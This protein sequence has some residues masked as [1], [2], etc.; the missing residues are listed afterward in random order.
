[1]T[2]ELPEVDVDR[3]N[4]AR[5]YD[6]MLGGSHN[7]ASDRA[8]GDAM[9][10]RFPDAAKAGH[11]NREFLHRAV[12]HCC[13]LGITQFLDLG[14]GIPTRGGVHEFVERR[15][16]GARVVYVDIEPVAVACCRALVEGNPR[17]RVALADLRDPAAV[18]SAPEV[19]DVLDLGAPVAVLAVASLHYVAP[20]DD[21]SAVVAAYRAALA[22]GSALVISHGS[23]DLDDEVAAG[24]MRDL[25]A[26]M[27]TSATPA[28]LRDRAEL[29]AAL[30]GFRLVD[31]GLV[32][33]RRWR[34]RSD[35]PDAAVYGALGVL[36]A[37]PATAP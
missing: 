24:H 16:P 32:D 25:A 13:S 3:P 28:Y 2:A 17:V 12:E 19:R 37:A 10:A 1:M 30:A 15:A 26:V 23:D 5:I 27:A 6:Y 22:P 20:A 14:S 31:P 9:L 29:R 7:F 34:D 18:L 36:D 4:A 8:A 11:A 21:L 35:L 33:I